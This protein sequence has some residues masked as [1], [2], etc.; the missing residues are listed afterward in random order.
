M[1]ETLTE[2][3]LF[4]KLSAEQLQKLSECGTEMEL[5]GGEVLFA[6]GDTNYDFYVIISGEIKITRQLGAEEVVIVVHKAGE[7]TG[8]LTMLM[9][10]E[11]QVTGR[12]VGNSRV[13]KINNFQHLL[14]S[15]P[16][17]VE[18]FV[19]SLAQR[20][21][22]L[23]VQLRE[24][25]KLAALGRLSA[26]LAHELNNPAAAG[27]RA[28]QQLNATLEKVQEQMLTLRNQYFSA[29]DR[30]L[31]QQ[32]RQE[33]VSHLDDSLDIDPME[34][35]DREDELSDWLEDHE[36][37]NSWQLAPTLV[38]VGLDLERLQT[39]AEQLSNEQ[40]LPEALLW[41]ESSLSVQGLVCQVE[42]STTRISELVQ[43][44]K[45][46]SYMDRGTLQEIDVHQG[47]N[48]TLTM[49]H[50]KLKYGVKVKRDYAPDVPKICVHGS[51]LNQ[52]WTNLIDN[53]IDAMDGKGELTIS[54]KKEHDCVLVEIIDN[55][56][57]IPPDIQAKVFEP[58]F[59]S[60]GVGV[61][62]GLGLDIVRRI[63]VQKH[64]GNIRFDSVPG[65][66]CFQIR[67]PIE[68]SCLE[69]KSAHAALN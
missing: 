39:L 51:E 49:L 53:A 38:A 64:Q 17:A 46:Y 25:D 27:K 14:N 31:L 8:D 22:E 52:V 58:F 61:G 21:K 44:I 59:T 60:K 41:L 16:Q 11:S 67:L 45:S 23:E 62:S 33:A 47:L 3:A 30:Q 68:Q 12:S 69:Q 34:L 28:A 56:A 10:N 5:S 2:S 42:Q 4:P 18:M 63:I 26:G 55:G 13:L 6:E 19:P 48:N 7:F 54:T 40:A 57:G 50:H 9:G 20:S 66:T 43:A 36:V 32:L 35:S 24:Q 29:E 65:R 1:S 37:E 15:C